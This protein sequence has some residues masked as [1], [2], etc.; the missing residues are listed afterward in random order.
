MPIH[1][2]VIS[3]ILA[4]FEGVMCNGYVPCQKKNFFGH[5]NAADFGAPIG[6]SGVT[7]GAGLD[8]GQQDDA[9]LERMGLSADLRRLF[10]PYLGKKR[11]AAMQALAA[12]PLSVSESQC[13]ALNRAVHTDYIRRAAALHDRHAAQAFADIPAQAQAVLV[14]LFY[15]LG[16]PFPAEGHPGYPTVFA[17]L[18]RAD[19]QAA[20][21]E[22]RT[23]FRRYASRR[24]QEADILAEVL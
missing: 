8:L 11:M 13:T 21:Q 2:D 6:A 22:L 16:S 19:W 1:Y 10:A 15:Q 23:G 9:A 4:R 5:G 14:S 24:K 18:C 20:V 17:L 3:D 7:I 12:A